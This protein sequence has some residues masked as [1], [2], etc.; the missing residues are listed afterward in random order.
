MMRE[1]I[2]T[3]EKSMTQ[4][5]AL[6][7]APGENMNQLVR[8]VGNKDDHADKL[9]DIVTQYFLKQRVKPVAMDDKEAYA[10]YERQLVLLHQV[11]VHSMKAKQTLE[12]SHIDTMRNL[13]DEF[14]A[15]YFGKAEHKHLEE[16]H[17]GE[18][19]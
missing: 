1:D 2:S 18:H 6:S 17:G 12:Q 9:S 14:E 8:W 7:A 3:L 4:I 5:K 15:V 11:M 19:K 16:A 13:V 10:K